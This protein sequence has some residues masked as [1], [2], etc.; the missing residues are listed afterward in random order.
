MP[1]VFFELLIMCY[2]WNL[3]LNLVNPLKGQPAGELRGTIV[4][5]AKDT[6][7]RNFAGSAVQCQLAP[8]RWLTVATSY[9]HFVCGIL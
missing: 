1:N 9:L 4:L 3:V 2:F 6:G 5:L 7:F 8:H